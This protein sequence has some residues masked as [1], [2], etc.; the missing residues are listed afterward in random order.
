MKNEAV[1]NK[2]K[3]KEKGEMKKGNQIMTLVI[4]NTLISFTCVY[5]ICESV[6]SPQ[7]LLNHLKKSVYG[8]TSFFQIWISH[9]FWM[10]QAESLSASQVL[11]WYLIVAEYGIFLDQSSLVATQLEKNVQKF[12]AVEVNTYFIWQMHIT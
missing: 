4:P 1:G 10:I 7:N 6:S 9:A 8:M 2:M 12:R 5:E 3:K 11:L